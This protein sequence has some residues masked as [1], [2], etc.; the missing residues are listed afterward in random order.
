MPTVTVLTPTYNRA[1]LL[2]NLY[3]SLMRQTSYDFIWMIVDDGS[4]DHTNEVVQNFSAHAAFETCY[5]H[6]ENGGKHTAI[7]V[8]IAEVKT[9]LTIIVDSDDVLLPEGIATI[10]QYQSK[11]MG[12]PKICGFSFLK[13]TGN[14]RPT[15]RLP[16]QEFVQGYIECRIKGRLKGDMAEVFYSDILKKYPFPEFFGEKFLSEDI[17]WTTMGEKYQ[18]VFVNQPIYQCEYLENGLTQ[19][20]KRLKFASPYG[21]ML[22]GKKLMISRCGW[23]S[24]IRGAIIYDCYSQETK[25]SSVL[26]EILQLQGLR[27]RGFALFMKPAGYFFNWH[28]KKTIC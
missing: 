9:P 21:S 24:W 22:R 4:N 15:L 27:C 19:N 12:Q 28:W 8:G 25:K 6:K 1:E 26:P 23:V 16:R 11:Y 10:I 17:V 5:L 2:K 18:L 3:E 20:D 13:V 14:K 7:N